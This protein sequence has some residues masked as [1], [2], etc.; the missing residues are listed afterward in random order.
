MSSIINQLR[1]RLANAPATQHLSIVKETIG[2]ITDPDERALA[3]CMFILGQSVPS[4]QLKVI[5]LVHG[6]RTHAVWQERLAEKLTSES[7]VEVYPI[8]YGYLDVVR[9]W[10]PFLTRRGPINRVLRE[11]RTIQ[12][13][14]PGAEISVVAH[15][16]GTYILSN[17][18]SEETDIKFQRIQLCGSIISSNYRWDKVI[19]RVT[20]KLVVN[21]AGTKDV[22]PILATL[23]T[24]GYGNSGTFGFKTA[25][26]KDRFH[27]CGHSDFFSD[28]HMQKY[29]V[30]LLIDGQII[31]STWNASRPS[32]GFIITWLNILPVKTIA[33]LLLVWFFFPFG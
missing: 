1:L 2:Q 6:I 31:S 18:L 12:S 27:N 8:G 3:E 28:G 5:V 7:N 11:L 15:S 16:F 32:P 10:C 26:V 22:W 21:D 24:W 30:P 9:F 33:G 4:T 13:N 20:G 17:I 23:M 29:W 25:N 14:H 19:S